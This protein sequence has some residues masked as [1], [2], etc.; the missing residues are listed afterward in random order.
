MLFR[1]A[2]SFDTQEAWVA[3]GSQQ[4]KYEIGLFFRVK[5]T[6][7]HQSTIE[8]DAQTANDQADGTSAS[9]APGP[10][11]TTFRVMDLRTDFARDEE[12]R[13]AAWWVDV[14]RRAGLRR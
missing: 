1:S 2:G 10:A 6:D 7:G 5:T 9:L 13:R 14:A 3:Y 12:G 4:G 11:N 8:A